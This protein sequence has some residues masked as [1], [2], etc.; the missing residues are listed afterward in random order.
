M[1]SQPDLKTRFVDIA[2][3]SETFADS[4]G[5]MIFDGVSL[6]VIFT[7]TRLDTPK[8]PKPPTGR[9]YPACRLV[10]TAQGAEELRARL[11]QMAAA[12]SEARKEQ[13]KPP[14]RPH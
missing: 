14:V 6:R 1:T 12:I 11:N 10:L 4:L 7:V 5:D 8:P 3:L 9:R 2:E 13:E